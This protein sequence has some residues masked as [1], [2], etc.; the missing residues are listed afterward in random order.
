MKEKMEIYG[1]ST[2]EQAFFREVFTHP[3]IRHT[4][5]QYSAFKYAF[6]KWFVFAQIHQCVYIFVFVNEVN[7][8]KR[9]KIA[10]YLISL[11]V[12]W[13]HNAWL[14]RILDHVSTCPVSHKIYLTHFSLKSQFVIT[15]NWKCSIAVYVLKINYFGC[16][17]YRLDRYK[18]RISRQAF[19]MLFKSLKMNVRTVKK[20]V[21]DSEFT[22]IKS[23]LFQD[24]KCHTIQVSVVIASSAHNDEIWNVTEVPVRCPCRNTWQL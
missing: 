22:A 17:D 20:H 18:E 23:K 19:S 5:V 12:A 8:E 9:C 3:R 2:K 10:K 24:I 14:I 1:L 4:Y 13:C 21:S 7:G 16:S 11:N 6:I 15:N